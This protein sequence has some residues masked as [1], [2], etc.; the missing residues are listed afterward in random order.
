VSAWIVLEKKRGSGFY[1][2]NGRMKKQDLL[3]DGAQLGASR[4]GSETNRYFI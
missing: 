4:V 2:S 3:R 1:G